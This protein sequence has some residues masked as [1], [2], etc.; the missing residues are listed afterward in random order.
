MTV[1]PGSHQLQ[2][3]SPYDAGCALLD[4]GGGLAAWPGPAFVLDHHGTSVAAN[5]AAAVLLAPSADESLL[6]AVRRGQPVTVAVTAGVGA[7]TRRFHCAVMPLV[8][9]QS[10]LVLAHETTLEATLRDALVESR[11][12]YKD[13]VEISGDFCWETGPD[14]RFVFVS[15]Q[16][17]VGWR[18]EE[19]VGRD[20]ALFVEDNPLGGVPMP[21][22]AQVHVVDVDLWF[23]R[24]EAGV[25]CLATTA[26][27]LFTRDG[28]WCGA[29]GLCRD[30][31]EARTR[32]AAIAGAGLRERL[33]AHV[34]RAVRDEIEPARMIAAAAAATAR[35]LGAEDCRIVAMPD[36]PDDP[37]AP[38]AAERAGADAALVA[39][40]AETGRPAD[41]AGTE[42]RRVLAV[43]TA[44]RGR[45]N[46]AV[47]VERGPDAPPWSDGDRALAGDV[48]AQIGIA[49][50]QIDRERRLEV[51]TRTDPLTGLLNRR[52]FE[53]ELGRRLD[54]SGL[55]SAQGA[56][57]YV[58][59]DNFKA[60]N[61][62]HGH[63]RGDDALCAVTR[64]LLR[65]TRPGDLVARLGGDEFALWLERT[66][67][68]TASRRAAE[69]TAAADT[70]AVYSGDAAHP[71][72]FSIGTAVFVPGS[73]E[74][75]AALAGRA[76]AAMY[77]VKRGGKG[78][79]AIAPPAVDER[80]G[81]SLRVPA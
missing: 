52:A 76:D 68:P 40:A 69:L 46:G 43:A 19:L 51:L 17:A 22:V 11:Q 79:F 31:T 72:G 58:D 47:V 14:G 53:A 48:A 39:R 27:P 73:D 49:L 70:L 8:C 75:L 35:A 20:P 62:R 81:R 9:G 65:G 60:V 63:A 54:R 36:D 3:V 29:R 45:P 18:A 25:A 66:D 57:V 30:V 44:F 80:S 74:T 24:P 21:F 77:A 37:D 50:A 26:M 7:A 1:P 12:R 15:P 71:F 16:G 6:I 5:D 78:G 42:G 23:R 67:A 59:L 13:L 38:P 34:A 64:L 4:D 33:L 41:D 55:S 56:L 2:A 61:D 32:D 10:A 28:V